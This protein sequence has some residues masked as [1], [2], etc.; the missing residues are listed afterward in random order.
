MHPEPDPIMVQ[1][2]DVIK[3]GAGLNCNAL[4]FDIVVKE[5]PES[6]A[7]S[8]CEPYQLQFGIE[9]IV[10]GDAYAYVGIYRCSEAWI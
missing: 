9:N 2:M 10:P 1:V 6:F 8:D 7:L 3:A 5:E 4:K